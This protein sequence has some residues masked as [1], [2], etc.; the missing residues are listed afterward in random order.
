MNLINRFFGY[1]F[2]AMSIMVILCAGHF[3]LAQE[4]LDDNQIQPTSGELIVK[5]TEIAPAS[6]VSVHEV[7][8]KFKDKLEDAEG[9]KIIG[10][11]KVEVKILKGTYK[12]VVHTF[13][14]TITS[15]P[16]N[17]HA[18]QGDKLLLRIKELS[19]GTFELVIKD[20]Y[21]LDSILLLGIILTIFFILFLGKF[22]IRI[23]ISCGALIGG[24]LWVVNSIVFNQTNFF[25]LIVCI[26]GL[27]IFLA[28]VIYGFSQETLI[29]L[30][31]SWFGTLT[32]YMS[33]S[34]LVKIFVDHD[35][36]QIFNTTL[37]SQ[38]FSAETMLRVV[39]LVISILFILIVSKFMVVTTRK[40]QE[41][42]VGLGFFEFL[43]RVLNQSRLKLV[44]YCLVLLGTLL[45][46]FLPALL[47]IRFRQ[48]IDMSQLFNQQIILELM[49]LYTSIVIG[50][51][52]TS[53]IAAI[54]AGRFL[55]KY[56]IS[57][58]QKK[59]L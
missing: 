57:S 48:E 39:I 5:H 16:N 50:I 29:I 47:D 53:I 40:I 25:A 19:D 14:N 46:L 37:H 15:N 32:V 45:G 34:F 7:P 54:F 17:V 2:I 12:G 24:V 4:I 26:I 13:E 28:F 52:I 1:L 21:Y 31:S 11:Q 36:N 27:L 51:F 58:K 59:L 6:V 20:V 9:Y 44:Q 22:A 43:V 18:R 3:V 23:L 42:T 10:I 56:K 38:L 49:I 55:Q 33:T 35:F 41:T 8:Q 30:L